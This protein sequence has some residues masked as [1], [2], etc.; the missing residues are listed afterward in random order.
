MT[1]LVVVTP[2]VLR[3]FAPERPEGSAHKGVR[4]C[5]LVIGGSVE[6][7]GAVLLAGIAALR[8]GAG[9]LQ[10]ATVESAARHL[11]V[12]VPEARVIGLEEDRGDISA[13]CASRLADLAANADAVLVGPGIAGEEALGELLA[14]LFAAP[15]QASFVID[16][17][18]LAAVTPELIFE[19]GGRVVLTPNAKE[20]SDMLNARVDD[21]EADPQQSLTS[22]VERF[23]CAV[24]LR[25]GETFSTAPGA[26]VYCD[27]SGSPGLGTSGSGDVLAGYLSGLLARGS[28]PLAASLWAVHVH[29]QSGQRL[30]SRVGALGYLAREL[31][32]EMTGVASE[33]G[34]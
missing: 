24:T 30:N 26:P 20:A 19:C 21:V 31:L 27:E 18:A 34:A 25:G 28:T 9:V 4:G 11:A 23:G 10:I 6:T 32:D 16:A 1:E 13:A 29:A 22:L 3:E 2:A 8:A 17:R 7:P 15:G 12:A 5:A 14:A 33:L